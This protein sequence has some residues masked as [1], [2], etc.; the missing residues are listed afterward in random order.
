MWDTGDV[1]DP[2][3]VCSLPV[4]RSSGKVHSPRYLHRP[5]TDKSDITS[6]HYQK[7]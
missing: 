6:M 5:R 2:V 1:S 7:T 3:V 4:D